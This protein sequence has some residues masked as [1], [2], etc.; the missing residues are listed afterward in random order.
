MANVSPKYE[1]LKDIF[2][3]CGEEIE[4]EAIEKAASNQEPG[5][6]VQ[7]KLEGGTSVNH[8]LKDPS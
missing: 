5:K 8:I 2:V 3:K 4:W 6:D 1:D 7:E